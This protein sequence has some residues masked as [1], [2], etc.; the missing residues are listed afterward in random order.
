MSSDERPEKRVKRRK[1]VDSATATASSSS[2]PSNFS[3]PCTHVGSER[4]ASESIELAKLRRRVASLSDDASCERLSQPLIILL[5]SASFFLFACLLRCHMMLRNNAAELAA[6]RNS[7]TENGIS[8]GEP[9]YRVQS[10]EPSISVGQ[11]FIGLFVFT[12]HLLV[13]MFKTVVQVALQLMVSFCIVP[14]CIYIAVR[15]NN[16]WQDLQILSNL[17]S[18]NV[19]PFIYSLPIRKIVNSMRADRKYSESSS[20]PTIPAI[21]P[22]NTD[23]TDNTDNAHE[24]PMEIVEDEHPTSSSLSDDIVELLE[25]YGENASSDDGSPLLRIRCDAPSNGLSPNVSPGRTVQ[26][27]NISG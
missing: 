10:V 8:V 21:A 19:M 26:I 15:R 5:A 13:W 20:T 17:G 7:L 16:V 3:S 22:T 6:L 27:Y 1:V 24:T 2:A 23:N 11:T 4:L 9:I 14:L 12:F 18:T 25:M